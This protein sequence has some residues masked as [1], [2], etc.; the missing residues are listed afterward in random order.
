MRSFGST[1]C[2]QTSCGLEKSSSWPAQWAFHCRSAR[3]SA[4]FQQSCFTRSS[5]DNRSALQTGSWIGT[6]LEAQ[7]PQ[8]RH[9]A[10]PTLEISSRPIALLRI[11]LHTALKTAIQSVDPPSIAHDKAAV[12]LSRPFA[13]SARAAT[14]RRYDCPCHDLIIFGL[15]QISQ[16]RTTPRPEG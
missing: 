12:T 2:R 10:A 1:A 15:D 16:R 3:K 11:P 6:V 7:R 4:R 5:A 9:H 8:C 14:P 13:T